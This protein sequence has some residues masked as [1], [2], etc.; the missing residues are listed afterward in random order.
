[1]VGARGASR[2]IC[3]VID[4]TGTAGRHGDVGIVGDRITAVGNLGEGQNRRFVGA[5]NG[6]VEALGGH[7]AARGLELACDVRRLLA[8]PLQRAL[9]R[10]ALCGR[11]REAQRQQEAEQH[12]QRQRRHRRVEHE[13]QSGEGAD[14][15]RQRERHRADG[16]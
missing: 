7:D 1:M 16:Q 12:E 5:E 8:L 9:E 13:P 14:A 10:P 11:F 15:G 6:I 3:T 2:I 4:G